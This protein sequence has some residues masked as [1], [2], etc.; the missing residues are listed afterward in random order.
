MNT[1]IK[2]A[3]GICMICAV[4]VIGIVIIDHK[5]Q[6][7]NTNIQTTTSDLE[8]L[9]IK[10]IEDAYA[11]GQAD[12]IK[13]DVRVKYLNDSTVVYTKNPWNPGDTAAKWNRWQNREIH[14]DMRN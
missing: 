6:D 8:S 2:L 10:D 11:S 3:I 14:I 12:A 7:I 1:R 9:F 13:G 4:A 5:Q